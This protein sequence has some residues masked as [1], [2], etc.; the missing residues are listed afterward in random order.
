[1]EV[2]AGGRRLAALQLLA[3]R[4][5]I[6][7]D[8]PVPCMV[9]LDNGEE[10]SLVENTVRQPMHPADQFEAFNRLVLAGLSVEDVAARFGV[11]P[12]F[13]SQRLKL[14]NVSP[15]LI[16]LYRDGGIRL[17]QLEA[18][19]IS[20]EHEAQERVW[21]TA[22]EWERTPSALRRALT[23]SAV[24]AQD[25]RVL[26][27]G[28]E[29][30]LGRGGGLERDLFDADHDGFLTD[31]CL[32]E[33]L[34]TEKLQTEADRLK[35]DGW[36]W[37]EVNRTEDRWLANR[38]YRKLQPK[39]VPL[40][41]ELKEED[42]QL[43]KELEVLEAKE[44]TDTSSQDQARIEQI[45]RRLAII[46]A[47]R[48]VYT[49]KQKFISG[50]M[51]GLTYNGQLA[52]DYGLTKQ[53][54]S[55]DCDESGDAPP[56]DPGDPEKLSGSLQQELTAQRT[57]AIRAELMARPDVALVT[58]THRLAGHFCYGSYESVPTAVM[59]NPVRFGLE[60]DLPVTIGSKA[61]EKLNA[62]AQAWAQRLPE[63]VEQLWDWL[64]DQPQ[65][66]I[67]D[68]LAFV[69]AQTINAVQLPHQRTDE[70]HLGAANAL[71]KALELDM[72]N[73]WAP[74]A[75]NYFQRIKK[76]QI[77][78][79]IKDVSGL[80]VPDRLTSMKKSDLAQEA[81]ASVKG[82]RWLPPVMRG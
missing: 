13:V 49:A 19:A 81:E 39:S 29:T 78:A 33:I 72:A 11:T 56:T 28:L 18:L 51:I 3:Q 82:T 20:N 36:S 69:V 57:V 68:L 27:V 53:R 76:D 70:G 42:A 8:Y 6:P 23:Q 75:E 2:V 14:A 7:K 41:K 67:L 48:Y 80:P 63:K 59:I 17:E 30:Y 26:F 55:K 4:K 21:N 10:L 66:V 65:N 24:D 60:P 22:H 43:R 35:A 9:V 37:V 64:I 71:S 50:V 40:S 44:D 34:V 77:L 62:A 46:E 16:Q 52:A 61:D 74:T 45:D 1:Y 54:V 12:L 25:K 79:A 47:S 58:I 38:T 31:G 32:L 5:T 73:W 15:T